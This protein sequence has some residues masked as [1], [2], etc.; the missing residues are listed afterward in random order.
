MVAIASPERSF[1][2]AHADPCGGFMAIPSLVTAP[3]GKKYINPD[4]DMVKK[5]HLAADPFGGVGGTLGPG[6]T[7]DFALTVPAEENHLGD[8][9]VSEI[10]ACFNAG[11]PPVRGI[12]TEILNLQSDRLYM[13]AP[14]ANPVL[15][16]DAFLNSCIPCCFLIQATNTVILRVTNT[17]LVDVECFFVAVGKRFLPY[18]AP[19]LRAR[20]LSY[21]NTI[22]STPYWLTLD[23]QTV[24]VAAGATTTQLMT[25]P[26]G[27]DFEVYWP[28]ADV[29]FVG[30]GNADRDI[31]VDIAEGVG[32]H[33]ENEPMPL[34]CFQAATSH[35][36]AGMPNN[37]LYS[38]VQARSCPQVTQLFKRNTRVRV[39][40]TNNAATDATIRFTMAGCMHYVGECPPGRSLDRLR[41]LEPTVGPSL[42]QQEF[43]CPPYQQ[44]APVPGQGMQPVHAVQAPAPVPPGG[45]DYAALYAHQQAQQAQ[46]RAKA[47]SDRARPGY[48]AG[49]MW[50]L[51]GN[52]PQQ[53]QQFRI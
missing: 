32:R 25:V 53:H 20:M 30:A 36:V 50:G 43:S 18:H 19:E 41:S 21:W 28:M 51:A 7:R 45:I 17:E 33:W 8:L 39:R 47:Q 49:L 23:N 16:G 37:G 42:I 34:G 13:N 31:D 1:A 24:T 52:Q 14:V 27:G 35:V 22:P 5:F 4:F 48:G 26:G 29:Q 12:M 44:M 3:N 2:S 38:A 15:W 46:S 6:Q 40:F 10:R 11:V 9:L